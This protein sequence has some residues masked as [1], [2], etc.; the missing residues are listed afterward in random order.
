MTAFT[1][2]LLAAALLLGTAVAVRA[3]DAGKREVGRAAESFGQALV[4]K[5]TG[6]L[7]KVL[8]DTGKVELSLVRLGPEEGSF[9]PTQVEALFRD[10]LRTGSVKSFELAAAEGDCRSHGLVRARVALVDRQGSPA[11]V[12]LHLVFQLEAGRWVLRGIREAAE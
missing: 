1:R 6:A 11:R 12:G 4:T 7:R 10:F 3:E 9:G 5:Q 8:P 2:G